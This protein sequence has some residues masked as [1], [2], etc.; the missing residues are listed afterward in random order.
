[1]IDMKYVKH[2]GV[3]ILLCVL[4][5]C[6]GRPPVKT[7]PAP[8]GGQ[9]KVGK[10]YKVSGKWYTPKVEPNYNKV[11]L[12]SWYGPKF[13]GRQTANGEIFNMNALTAA[14]TTLPMPSYVRVTNLKNGR[15]LILRV[16]D[17]GPFVGDRI[18]D[19]SRRSA[20]LLGFEKQGVT[21]VRVQVVS[22]P[23]GGAPKP[24]TQI[25]RPA[26]KPEPVEPQPVIVEVEPLPATEPAA[27]T[28]KDGAPVYIQIGAYS[29]FDRAEQVREDVM[30]LGN[31]EVSK[32]DILGQKLFRVRVGPIPTKEDADVTL[33]RILAR[34]HNTAKI[35]LK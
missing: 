11:G 10:P 35:M 29:E 22:G 33:G 23:D 13:H 21:R 2:L 30:H 31:I 5:A 3:M 1:M 12:A 9:Y 32:V 15:W 18:I 16:N 24:A 14:H 34:G 7:E 25:V 6:G 19:V 28:P 4:A 27:D 26:P 8:G 17:R 20:Q